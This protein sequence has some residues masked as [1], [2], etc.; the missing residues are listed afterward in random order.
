MIFDNT[1]PIQ[2]YRDLITYLES[3]NKEKTEWRIGTEHEKFAFQLSDLRPLPYEGG[4]VTFFEKFQ[5]FGWKPIFE[6]DL[7]MGLEKDDCSITLEPGGQIELSGNP[8]Q[9]L[10]QTCDQINEHLHQ[11]RTIGQEMDVGLLGLGFEP[12]WSYHDMPQIPKLRYH[13]V[14]SYMAKQGSHGLDMMHR[15]CC[16]SSQLRLS[17]RS[18]YGQ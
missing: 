11:S 4:I 3:G 8:L 7:L 16:I 14:R 6:G 2:D 18:G 10:H 13:H 5:R 1:E 15:T 9:T 17:K 12:K